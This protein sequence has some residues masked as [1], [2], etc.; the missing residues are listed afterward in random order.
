MKKLLRMLGAYGTEELVLSFILKDCFEPSWASLGY[1]GVTLWVDEAGWVEM[2]YSHAVSYGVSD[3]LGPAEPRSRVVWLGAL[4]STMTEADC[5]NQVP[6]PGIYRVY[7]DGSCTGAPLFRET[8]HSWCDEGLW[9]GRTLDKFT[10]MVFRQELV[11]RCMKS[12]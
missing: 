12:K 1:H 9:P 4:S 11:E 10:V 2:K 8:P 6:G 5:S 7:E 3:F